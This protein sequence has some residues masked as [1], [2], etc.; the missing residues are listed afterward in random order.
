MAFHSIVP[1]YF[2]LSLIVNPELVVF[3]LYGIAEESPRRD[4]STAGME[5]K[6]LEKDIFLDVSPLNN[7][8]PFLELTPEPMCLILVIILKYYLL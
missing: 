7:T 5:L 2:I 4:I 1:V 3:I 6:G 8:V